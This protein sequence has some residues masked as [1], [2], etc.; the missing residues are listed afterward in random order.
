MVA[1]NAL[2]LSALYLAVGVGVELLRAHAPSGALLRLS[3]ALDSL[4]ARVL[5]RLGLLIPLREA[6]TDG[7]VSEPI[8]RLIFGL[9]AVLFVFLLAFLI[10]SCTTLLRHWLARRRGH[11]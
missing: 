6:Y 8:V 2:A 4:P 1:G 5:E 3:Y 11:I 7:R 10:G 9:T